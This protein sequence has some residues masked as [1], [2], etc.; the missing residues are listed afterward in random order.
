MAT[1]SQKYIAGRQIGLSFHM[2]TDVSPKPEQS[3]RTQM[4]SAFTAY[5]EKQIDLVSLQELLV[6]AGYTH[7]L[8]N[9]ELYTFINK[10]DLH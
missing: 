6:E 2:E 9:N 10:E 4:M 5:W 1:N 8:E 7:G 3:V